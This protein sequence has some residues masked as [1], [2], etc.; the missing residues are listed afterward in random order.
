MPVASLGGVSGWAADVSS[1][2]QRHAAN[3]RSVTQ[4]ISDCLRLLAAVVG[5]GHNEDEDG[6]YTEERLE[7]KVRV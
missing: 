2:A 3:Q 5:V 1:P 4:P 7:V 6:K